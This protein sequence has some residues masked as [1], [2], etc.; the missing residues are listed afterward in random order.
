MKISEVI[1]TLEEYRDDYG[2]LEVELDGGYC[3]APGVIGDTL[4]L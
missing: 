1:K 3:I 4:Y 2:D